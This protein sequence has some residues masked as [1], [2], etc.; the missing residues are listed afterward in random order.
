MTL[1]ELFRTH[2][3]Q[4]VVKMRRFVNNH[5]VAEDI[6]QDA[7]IR[8]FEKL[9]QYDRKRG[10]MKT[11]F[12]SVLFSVLWSHKKGVK[13]LPLQSNIEDYLNSEDCGISE[14]TGVEDVINEM[15]NLLHRQVL[16]ATMVFGY[17]N[18]EVAKTSNVS[19]ENVKKITQRFRKN[20]D[21]ETSLA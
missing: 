2:K 12:H 15:T 1:E 3:E 8:A 14:S 6:V 5:A 21:T 16:L 17:S 18:E 9:P 4:Y 7:F 13:R 19:V 20:Y 11:W 10:T